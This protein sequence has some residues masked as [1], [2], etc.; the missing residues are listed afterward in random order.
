[1]L[2]PSKRPVAI[3]NIKRTKKAITLKT[4]NQAGWTPF[5]HG[6]QVSSSYKDPAFSCCD[7]PLLRFESR[8]PS[9]FHIRNDAKIIVMNTQMPQSITLQLD[10]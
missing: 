9:Y 10:Q 3:S 4:S 1:M 5:K 6:F 7:S 8:K 2:P